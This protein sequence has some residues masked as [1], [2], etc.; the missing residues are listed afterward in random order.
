M[1]SLQGLVL[2]VAIMA[3][4]V[5]GCDGENTGG[6]YYGGGTGPSNAS[7]GGSKAV[8]TG[9]GGVRSA[10]GTGGSTSD[11]ENAISCTLSTDGV[12]TMCFTAPGTAEGC[13][14][15]VAGQSAKVV[16]QCPSGELLTC[17]IVNGNE[18]A[19]MHI[20]DQASVNA[21]ELQYPSDPCSVFE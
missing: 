10:N 7:V 17:R 8:Q 14:S 2:G 6:G 18:A 12:L 5:A 20:Y 15:S 13:A 11:G 9:V 19:T 4:A 21:L 1:E 3:G 16:S